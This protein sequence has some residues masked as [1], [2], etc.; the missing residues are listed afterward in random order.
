MKLGNILIV[1]DTRANLDVLAGMLREHGYKV[2]PAP[3]GRLALRAVNAELPDLI[4]LD[5][6]MPEMDGYEVCRR[7]KADERFKDIPIIFISALTETADKLEAFRIGGVDYI[8]K[9]FHA[10]EVLARVSVH[11]KLQQTLA[12]LETARSAA[13]A[14]NVAKSTFLRNM[15]H[16][17]RSPLNIILGY[18]RLMQRFSRSLP[19]EQRDNLNVILRSGEHLN[20]LIANVLDLSRIEAGKIELEPHSFDL[21]HF[22]V[23]IEDMFAL[24][25]SDKSLEFHV[26]PAENCPQFI[27]TDP[28]KLRQI[29]I[30]LLS[31]ALTFTQDGGVVVRTGLAAGKTEIDE[32][33]D[34]FVEVEDS[35]PGIPPH[36]LDQIFTPF[37]QGEA[38]KLAQT[39]TGL[40]LAISRDFSKLLGSD[41]EI[42]TEFGRGTKF[43]FQIPVEIVA[44]IEDPTDAEN[45]QV[46]TLAPDQANHKILIADDKWANRQILFKLLQPLG[47]DLREAR[48]GKEAVEIWQ[49][50][51]P[52]LVW[53]HLRMPVMDGFEATR[54]IKTVENGPETIVIAVTA[55]A[56]DEERAIIETIGSDD[57]LRRPYRLTDVY[58]MLEKHLQVRFLYDGVEDK[59]RDED[60]A[61]IPTDSLKKITPEI[62]AELESAIQRLDIEV[63]EKIIAQ[64]RT[65]DETLADVLDILSKDFNYDPIL[66]EIRKI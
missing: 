38:G 66:A 29:L 26:E 24:R 52:D 50:W 23:D 15:S 47:F 3:N 34:L 39:G 59:P 27:K 65:Q 18:A 61:K 33:V 5:I 22:L 21:H 14:A 46:V 13:E 1:D 7:L 4:L 9:P 51:E 60:I 58:A 6:R 53:L 28:V 30:N 44:D 62:L 32:R 12:E 56:F 54:Q 35:G 19:N 25:A 43:H 55:S 42:E 2:R 16:E 31:N 36:E 45:Q 17:L 8:T 48:N 10:E 20:T 64:I 49:D 41:L 63:V 11:L 57:F 40:G 37:F